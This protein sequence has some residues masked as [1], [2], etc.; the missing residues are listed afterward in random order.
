MVRPKPSS[1]SGN[2]WLP[3][4]DLRITDSWDGT[5]PKFEVGKPETR[6]ITINAVGV[7]SFAIG[8]TDL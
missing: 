3:A 8:F 5:L 6:K 7:E 4:R 2:T 1:F